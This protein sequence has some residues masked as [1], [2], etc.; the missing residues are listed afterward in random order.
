MLPS[1]ETQL[2]RLAACG[3]DLLDNGIDLA[4][5]DSRTLCR[6]VTRHLDYLQLML[7]WDAGLREIVG[8]VGSLYG[9]VS[10]RSG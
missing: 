5:A 1:E 3:A 2:T 10:A 8:L 4:R 7:G 9:R 6:L